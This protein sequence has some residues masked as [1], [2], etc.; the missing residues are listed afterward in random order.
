MVVADLRR[1]AGGASKEMFCFSLRH[2]ALDAPERLVLRMDPLESII[3]TSR[4]R[5]AEAVMAARLVV[6]TPLV[7]YLDQAGEFLGQSA[8]ITSFVEGVTQP[9]DQ[10]GSGVSGLGTNYGAAV[11]RIAPQFLDNLVAIHTLDWR[12]ARLPSFQAPDA[13]PQQAALWQANWYERIWLQ[14]A[15]EAIPLA[16]LV[17]QWL[18]E[19]APSCTDLCFIHGDYRMGNFMFDEDSGDMTAV[20]DWELAHIGDFHEDLAYITQKLFGRVDEQGRFLCCGLFTREEFLRRYQQV[21][22]RSINPQVLHY[23]E[24]LNAWK[25][26]VHTF[27]TCLCVANAGNNHQDVLLSWLAPVGHIL[28]NEIVGYLGGTK[29]S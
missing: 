25:S 4:Q 5:E 18:R 23:Y 1:L 15:A 28:L 29:L 26:V 7:R 2:D 9:R 6:P 27:A 14:D 12:A 3:E 21:S 24:V 10:G 17:R 20:L 11:A 16:S 8:L 13:Y 19:N 22:G